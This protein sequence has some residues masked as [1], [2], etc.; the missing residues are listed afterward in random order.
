MQPELYAK[1]KHGVPHGVP[2]DRGSW[3]ATAS[4]GRGPAG[5]GR[6]RQSAAIVHDGQHLPPPSGEPA[7]EGR[8]LA[9][10]VGGRLVR[11]G[12]RAIRGGAVDSRRVRPGHIFFALP[13]EHTDGQRFVYDAVAAGAAAV[14]LRD[15]PS[16][17]QLDWLAAPTPGSSCSR[18]RTPGAALLAAARAWRARWDPL[19]VGITGSLAKTST[20]EQIAEVLAE[21]WTV[22]RNEGNENNEVGLPLT[23][24]RSDRSTRRWCSRWAC[25]CRATSPC[26]RA[27]PGRPSAW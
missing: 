5:S 18:S 26:W 15:A 21:R 1:H 23:L 3:A 8:T 17:A 10:A 9:A 2:V 12:H 19:V 16:D 6:V 25:T 7:F 4:V 13:G 20:K 27:W 11:E 24:L 22:L 14:V